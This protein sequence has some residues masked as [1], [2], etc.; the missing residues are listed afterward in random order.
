M[1]FPYLKTDRLLLRGLKPE[2]ALRVRLL[3]GDREIADTTLTIS[4]PFETEM[5]EQY[6][7]GKILL[8]ESSKGVCFAVILF[9]EDSLIGVI[10]LKNIDQT[11]KNA[12]L[13][14]WIGKE[15]WN[16]GY[17]TEAAV[18]VV[19]Y[20]FKELGL[21]RIYAHCIS[22]NP[23]SSKVLAKIGM[24]H[25]GRLRQHILKWN[26]FEDIDLYGILR[27][28]HRLGESNLETDH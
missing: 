23:S 10:N 3:A 7:E 15:Y 14:Y 28:E 1:S 18:A 22:R 16:N 25:E 24:T 4:H 2:D 13:G 17:A 11:H 27:S 19:N 12:E 6:V 26:E 9:A 21:Q 5:A 20:G 8:Y